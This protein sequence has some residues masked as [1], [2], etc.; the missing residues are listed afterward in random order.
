[1]YE[2]NLG[3]EVGVLDSQAVPISQVVLRIGFTVLRGLCRR[4]GFPAVREVFLVLFIR[5]L[6]V[7]VT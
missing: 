4:A 5:C 7:V 2:I 1:M 6:Y 3:T